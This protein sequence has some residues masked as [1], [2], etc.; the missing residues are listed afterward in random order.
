MSTARGRWRL[1]AVLTLGGLFVACIF[2]YG[3]TNYG[4]T[5]SPDSEVVYLTAQ[6]ISRLEGV[7]AQTGLPLWPGFG[8]APGR[9]GK[10]YSVFGPVQSLVAA[11]LVYVASRIDR[12]GW[13]RSAPFP[14]P[15][16]HYQGHSLAGLLH[17]GIRPGDLEPH[18]ERFLVSFLNTFVTSI[19]VV[20]FAVMLLRLGVTPTGTGLSAILYAF[21]SLAWPYAGT[22]FSEPLAT[23]WALLSLLLLV[24]RP[25][26]SVALVLSGCLLGLGVGT[27]VS[28]VLFLPFFALCAGGYPYIATRSARRALRA[29]AL[30][31]L[32]LLPPLAALAAYNYYRFGNILETG[33]QVGDLSTLTFGYGWFVWPWPNLFRLLLSPGKGLLLFCPAVVLGGLGWRMLRR[34]DPLLAWILVGAAGLR[35]L[36]IAARSDWP[37]GACLGPRYLLMLV[38]FLLLPAGFV[39]DAALAA[40]SRLP[41]AAWLAALAICCSQQLAFALGE[42]FIYYHRLRVACLARGC[43]VFENDRLY[44]DWPFSPLLHILSAPRAPFLLQTLAVS[45]VTLWWVGVA[46]IGLLAMAFGLATGD[47]FRHPAADTKTPPEYP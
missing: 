30:W 22:F 11:P 10:M 9:D 33:R 27:H 26:R 6:T 20:V 39:A 3:V 18:A 36:F 46:T 28:T 4:G 44:T 1:K 31:G 35:L 15:I 37:A 19:S 14:I 43:N 5:R 29:L 24:G 25:P 13:Y 34:K 38:P 21:G 47:R 40:C 12:T 42:I 41:L 17:S 45:N 8:V 7:D 2:V 32:G 16:S 23:C